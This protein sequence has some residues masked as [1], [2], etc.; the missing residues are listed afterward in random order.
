M[1]WIMAQTWRTLLFAHWPLPPHVLRPLIPSG[2]SLQT[3]QRNAWV[4]ITAFRV[5]GLRPRAVPALP[6]VS[7]FPE[8]NVRTYVTAGGKPG[9]FFF[10]L[11]AGSLLA[12]T[13][14]RALYSLPYFHATFSV[15]RRRGHIV[16]SSRRH[17]GNAPAEFRAKYW[18]IGNVMRATPETLDAWLTERYCLYAVNRRGGLRRAEIHH[19]PWPLQPA[20]AD[21][22]RNTMTQGLGFRLPDL[23]PLLHFSERLDVHVWGPESITPDSIERARRVPRLGQR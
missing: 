13:A 20:E 10:S 23:P 3:F 16:Y 1:P 18:P 9:V 12:V 11:D 8:I 6:V 7:Q 15:S 22:Q 4:G 21:I 5:T 17:Q 2:L 19:P 14:A